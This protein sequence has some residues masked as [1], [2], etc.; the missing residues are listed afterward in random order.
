MQ[1]DTFARSALIAGALALF[2]VLPGAAQAVGS[3]A[4]V[5]LIDRST[6]QTLPVHF[7]QGR[8]W[9][10]GQPGR[11]FAVR[12][13]NRSGG[14][15][16]SVTSIDGVNVISGETAGSSQSGYVFSP[17]E[18]Y[19]LTGWRKSQ[20]QVAAF[21]FTALPDSYAARTGR[22]DDV[23]V[24]GVALFREKPPAVS[25]V[26]PRPMPYGRRD[27][28]GAGV[29]MR[30]RAEAPAAPAA[31]APPAGELGSA[32]KSAADAMG[33]SRA[34]ARAQAEPKLGTGH[35]QR[36][37]APVTYTAFQRAQET[38]DEVIVIHYDSRANL[39]AMGVI[40]EPRPPV[41]PRPFPGQPE[42]G[43]VPDPP[44]GW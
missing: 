42:L 4:D 12:V 43:F 16:L 28:S 6:G 19:D 36:E 37:T 23:G 20:A 26:V 22:P 21:Y 38:P 11:N 44:R 2:S 30:E 7:H 40:S 29:D 3:L 39:L 15:L 10:A 33:E 8:Y 13:H 18:R 17:W 31:A 1:P 14:R 32:S 5:S 41:R 25:N 27:G 34:P 9:V 24:I 35:G